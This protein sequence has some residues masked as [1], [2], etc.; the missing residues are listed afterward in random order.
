MPCGKN[1]VNFTKEIDSI[2]VPIY[3]FEG[4]YDMITPPIQVERFYQNLVAERGKK[5]IIF[6]NSAHFPMLEEKEKYEELLINVV[7]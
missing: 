3:F 1:Y 5:L 7:L 2:E 6:K 4:K